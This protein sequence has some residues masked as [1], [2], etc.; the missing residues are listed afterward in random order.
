[1][2]NWQRYAE[3]ILQ[4]HQLV[5]DVHSELALLRRELEHVKQVVT[6]LRDETS[7]TIQ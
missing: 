7:L 4:I 6:E 5:R 3:L 1:M 2:G